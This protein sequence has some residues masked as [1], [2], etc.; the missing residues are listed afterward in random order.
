MNDADAVFLP[1]WVGPQRFV[2]GAGLALAAGLLFGTS[3]D[4][5]QYIID[6]AEVRHWLGSGF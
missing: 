2:L 6:H 1:N 4:P 3:F 5:S